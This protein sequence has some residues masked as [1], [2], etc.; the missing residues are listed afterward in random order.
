METGQRETVLLARLASCQCLPVAV[1][2]NETQLLGLQLFRLGLLMH[3]I[4]D[5]EPL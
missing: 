2:D 4:P 3:L 1:A 5:S